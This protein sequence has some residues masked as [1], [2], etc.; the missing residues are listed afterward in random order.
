[1]AGIPGQV[2]GGGARVGAGRKPK[3]ERFAV[4]INRA[5]KNI[6][7]KLPSLIG[8][9]LELA[10]GVS[11]EE[12]DKDGNAH[13]F[14]RPPDFKA[15]SYLVDRIMG[16]PTTVVDAEIMLDVS[17]LTDAELETLITTKGRG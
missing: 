1:M 6:A 7:D 4:A 8:S 15:A 3:S 12:I 5:E 13:V 11:V 10:R 16:K 17:S 14:T 2:G 9:L